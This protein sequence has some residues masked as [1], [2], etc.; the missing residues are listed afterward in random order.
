MDQYYEYDGD[1]DSENKGLTIGGYESAWCADLAGAYVLEKT[2][3]HFKHSRYYGM[4][5][6]DGFGVLIGKWNYQ[7]V[8]NWRN[9]F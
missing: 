6:D 4:Y 5:R 8:V 1:E 3:Q 7:E 9:S 2:Q